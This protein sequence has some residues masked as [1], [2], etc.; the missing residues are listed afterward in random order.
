[1]AATISYSTTIK[2]GA[3]GAG[4]AYSSPTSNAAIGEVTSLSFDGVAQ[5]SLEVTS[6]TDAVKKYKAG[7][8]DPGSISIELNLDYDDA[9]QVAIATASSDRAL[10]SY[11]IT[12]GAAATGG[13]TISGVGVVTGFSVK[14]ATDTVLTVSFS[15]KCSAAYTLA[16]I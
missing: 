7:I 2:I 16:A 9:Q 8:L 10:R 4:D 13:M 1:M 15:I 11:L 3:V 6:I 14:A 5:S 12:F